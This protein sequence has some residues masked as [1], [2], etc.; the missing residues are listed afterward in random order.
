[1]GPRSAVLPIQAN[2]P[3]MPIL[4]LVNT[5]TDRPSRPQADLRSGPGA[6]NLGPLSFLPWRGPGDHFEAVRVGAGPAR[7]GCQALTR[8]REP[9]GLVPR[10]SGGR[11]LRRRDPRKP[12]VGG[13]R[14]LL[15][16]LLEG[17][18]GT[19]SG[20]GPLGAAFAAWMHVPYPARSNQVPPL[21]PH[22]AA[23]GEHRADEGRSPRAT[24]PSPQ[25]LV[26]LAI[27]HR[28][29]QPD[30]LGLPVGHRSAAPPASYLYSIGVT[31]LMAFVQ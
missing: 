22:G 31:Q 21:D 29:L 8:A 7:G 6:R 27:G 18:P 25:A 23:E 19:G 13:R 4:L 9:I 10:R 24:G 26:T 30:P 28:R 16:A 17:V 3:A 2:Y 14:P 15:G 11:R 1:M 5:A 12:L 20:G